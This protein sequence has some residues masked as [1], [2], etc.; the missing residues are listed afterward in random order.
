MGNPRG[1]VEGP[2][3]LPVGVA[4]LPGNDSPQHE[5]RMKAVVCITVEST[6]CLLE[7]GGDQN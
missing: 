4:L 6:A 7:M 5:L 3:H 2:V 1:R